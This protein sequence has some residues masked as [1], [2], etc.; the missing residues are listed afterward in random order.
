MSDLTDRTA[1]VT[2]ASSGIGR[3]TAVE[4]A[5]RG[6]RV[7]V[8]YRDADALADARETVRLALAAHRAAAAVH[9][10]DGA[11][12]VLAR[13]DE[14]PAEPFVPANLNPAPVVAVEGDV[15]DERSVEAMFA[16]ATRAFGRVDLLVNNAGIQIPSETHETTAEAFDAVMAVNVRGAFL[17]ARAAL[18]DMLARSAGGTIVNV[19]SVHEQIPRPGFASYAMS[20]AALGSLTKTLALEYADRGIRVN[21]VAPGATHTP[22]Q[23]WFGDAAGEAVVAEHIPLARVARPEEIARVIAFLAS[24]DAAYI[25]GQTL[26]ADGGLTL[27]N[28][29]RQPW[30]G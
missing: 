9:A 12:P 30:S 26:F 29:F 15:T 7:A 23:S 24:D 14:A 10:G 5:R 18:R 20:K 4:L 21:A 27:Y 1:L 8:G 22:I 25:T 16:A 13:A 2:G 6:A 3:A 28:D 11:P 19:S 17:C